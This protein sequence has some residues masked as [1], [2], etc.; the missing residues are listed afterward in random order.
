M[1]WAPFGKLT[2]TH[3]LKGELKLRPF[4]AD[5][6]LCR[7]GD[8]VLLA[9]DD[10]AAADDTGREYA[11]QSIRGSNAAPIVKFAGCDSIEAARVLRGFTVF[12]SRKKFK[13][14]P[15]G[16]YYWF[17]V[18]G[19]EAYDEAGKFYGCVS[20]VIETG[21]NDVYVVTDGDRELLLPVID[22][23]IKSVDLQRNKLVFH[24]VEG[25]LEETAV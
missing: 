3:G 13:T 23:V 18:Q 20:E 15:E 5:A 16:R 4:F 14:L 25:L 8:G 9:G 7:R 1:D 10:P 12:V 6:D 11:V 17:E 24:I 22:W 21:S 2:R 19:L